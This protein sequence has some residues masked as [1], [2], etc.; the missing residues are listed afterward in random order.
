MTKYNMKLFTGLMAVVAYGV[1][2]H[3]L[4]AGFPATPLYVA[5]VASAGAIGLIIVEW[6]RV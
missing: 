1:S 4:I 2:A 6:A 3:L 5:M